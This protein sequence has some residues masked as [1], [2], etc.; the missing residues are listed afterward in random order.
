[1]KL[2]CWNSSASKAN[3]TS[4]VLRKTK[5]CFTLL[6][7]FSFVVSWGQQKEIQGQL[8]NQADI[9]GIHVL[10]RSSRKNTV[11]NTQGQF[12]I[13][14]QP[15]DTLLISSINYM[16][17]MVIVSDSIHAS[18]RMEITLRDLVNELAEVFVGRKLS[19]HLINDAK[20]IKVEDTINFH[21]VG[22][23]GF[24][25]KPEEKIP[26]LLGQV[27]TPL[28]IDVE[29]LYKYIS[30][31]YKV[32]KTQRQWEAENNMVAHLI[33]YYTPGFYQEAY[34]IPEDRLYDFLL[35]T[36]ETTNIQ[37]DFRHENF[38]GVLQALDRCGSE[39]A[40]RLTKKE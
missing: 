23:P 10:N 21:D 4:W 28:S 13:Q 9:E 35:F 38:V 16:P 31:Y 5:P 7:G 34:G 29:G 11:T 19:G 1:M 20:N 26:K 32:L 2:N 17:E 25:G 39:Y 15:R 30:G 36:I 18:G 24:R 6:V 8:T 40:S 33:H 3:N 22:I 14:A 37:H 12:T 27:I